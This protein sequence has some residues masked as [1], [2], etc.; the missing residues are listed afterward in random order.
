MKSQTIS[1][2]ALQKA[3][4]KSWKEWFALLKKIKAGELSHKEI[5]RKLA[6]EYGVDG[7][8]A[9]SITVEFERSI[10]RREVG[11]TCE[12]DYQTA[13]SKTLVG[14][15][16]HAL[17]IWQKHIGTRKD[18][19]KVKFAGAPSVSKTDKWRYWRVSLSDGSKVT[20][21][22]GQKAGDKT[23]LAVNHDNLSDKKAVD[24]WKLYWKNF[25]QKLL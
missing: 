12:G 20:V 14:D 13:A 7:W 4:S 24:R 6:D 1:D 2:E 18:F 5:A 8:W 11:Q 9:Q 21:V 3:T 16:D 10:G 19:D 23:S 25:L 22:I 15:M 17:R